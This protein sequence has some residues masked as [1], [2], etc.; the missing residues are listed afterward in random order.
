MSDLIKINTEQQVKNSFAQQIPVFDLVNENHPL[1]RQKLD[2]FDFSKPP[3]DPNAFASSLV[4]TCKKYNGYGLS[5]NQCGFKHRVFV[6]G[7]GDEYVAMFNPKVLEYSPDGAMMVEGCLSFSLLGLR[8]SRASWVVVE[9]QDFTGTKHQK[10][11]EGLSARCFLHELDHM[12]GIVFTQRAKP[13]ALKSGVDKRN[14]LLRQVKKNASK[15]LAAK[16]LT[17]GK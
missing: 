17:N 6:M 2:E 14:K 4:E 12:D 5:A 8:I 15:H 13:L 1:L 11:F 10:R 3:V 9:Y 16:K 7:A